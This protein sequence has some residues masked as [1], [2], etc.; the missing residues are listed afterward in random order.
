M[1]IKRVKITASNNKTY[2]QLSSPNKKPYWAVGYNDELVIQANAI[3]PK[4]EPL[5]ANIFVG[6]ELNGFGSDSWIEF[7]AEIKRL[8]LTY[9]KI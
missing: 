4:D 7:E 6:S 8:K 3:T 2:W 1:I 5:K 9:P